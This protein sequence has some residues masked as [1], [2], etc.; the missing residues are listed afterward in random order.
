MFMLTDQGMALS[1]IGRTNAEH[2][3]VAF[4]TSEGM[5]QGRQYI[6]VPLYDILK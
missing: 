2:H 3:S 1:A 6:R 4:Q 5:L